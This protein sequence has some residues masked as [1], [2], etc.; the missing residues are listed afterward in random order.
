MPYETL[1]EVG[2]LTSRDG[3][4]TVKIELTR[5]TS[6]SNPKAYSDYY[7]LTGTYKS[8]PKVLWIPPGYPTLI[9]ALAAC[10][11]W[12]EDENERPH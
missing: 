8:R 5:H 12:L 6:S 11:H 1:H 3:E 9:T 4:L 10:A 7:S 2:T